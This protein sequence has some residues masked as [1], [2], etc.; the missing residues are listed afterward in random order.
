[1]SSVSRYHVPLTYDVTDR[2]VV[3]DNSVSIKITL[4]RTM[5]N[6]ETEFVQTCRD[7]L[8]IVRICVTA[9]KESLLSSFTVVTAFECSCSMTPPE[10]STHFVHFKESTYVGG[11]CNCELDSTR[12]M[13][14]KW[15]QVFM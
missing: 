5:D 7:L 3:E 13:K 8:K 12:V 1:M 9:V 15:L 6:R 4:I 11:K 2:F 10:G 14:Q